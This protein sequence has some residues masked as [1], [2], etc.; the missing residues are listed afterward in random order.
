L[1]DESEH[2]AW[3]VL[4]AANRMQAKGSTAR[5]IVPRDP[6]VISEVA[7][8]LSLYPSDD[9]LLSAEEYL[10]EGGYIAPVDIGLTRGSYSVTPV[11][12]DWLGRSSLSSPRAPETVAE[13]QD[14]AESRSSTG[15]SQE[16]T[17]RSFIQEEPE[18]RT[19]WRR[20]FG[21]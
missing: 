1:S 17:E 15:G 7:Q 18:F 2:F 11:G 3:V 14:R 9:D 12:L 5:V 8:E 13:E 10:L 19:W 6:E 21:R 4:R 16:G 20:V